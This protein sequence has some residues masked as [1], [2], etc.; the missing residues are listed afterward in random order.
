MLANSQSG[1]GGKWQMSFV[2]PS[3]YGADLPLPK[4]ES[5]SIT[6]VPG[7]VVAVTAFSGVCK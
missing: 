6:E 3:K 2:M 1:D 4:D 5:V 7:K